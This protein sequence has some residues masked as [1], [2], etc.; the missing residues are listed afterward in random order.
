[1]E[2]DRAV[3]VEELEE[4]PEEGPALVPARRRREEPAL[5]PALLVEVHEGVQ[6]GHR[7][8]RP[9][10]AQPA[11]GLRPAELAADLVALL[12]AP[13]REVSLEVHARLERD[14]GADLLRARARRA[15]PP[16]AAPKASRGRRPPGR[17]SGWPAVRWDV[18]GRRMVGV[19]GDTGVARA[20]TRASVTAW[21]SSGRARSRIV[22]VVAGPEETA[23]AVGATGVWGMCASPR[24]RVRRIASSGSTSW[25]C[26]SGTMATGAATSGADGSTTTRVCSCAFAP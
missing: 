25:R 12:L 6:V 14:D 24:R 22:G 9:L 13:R 11:R 2:L 17:R 8:G 18:P 5:A 21:R 1:V 19:V 15:S 7:V 3:V 23:L 26:M 10:Q 4:P 20:S 16:G